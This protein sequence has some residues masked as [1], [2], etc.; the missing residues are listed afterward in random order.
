MSASSLLVTCGIVTQLRCRFGPE[1]FLMRESGLLLDRTELREIELRPR[2]QRERHRAA[3]RSGGRRAAAFLTKFWTSS[4]VMRPLRRRASHEPSVDTEFARETA[5][6]RTACTRRRARHRRPAA[7]DAR[8]RLGLRR[9]VRRRFGADGRRRGRR[10]AAEPV[11]ARRRQ[12][13]T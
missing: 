13:S 9:P 5:D 4:R 1:I 2:R 10:A 6:R 7:P 8:R 3:R 11:L 12:R